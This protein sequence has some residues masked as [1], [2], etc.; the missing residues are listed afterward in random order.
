MRAPRPTRRL[1]NEA[2]AA[3][4]IS[5]ALDRR[6]LQEQAAANSAENIAR[7]SELRERAFRERRKAERAAEAIYQSVRRQL[8]TLPPWDCARVA[9]RLN[10]E[11]RIPGKRGRP[12]SG[13]HGLNWWIA[14]ELP[15]FQ[16]VLQARYPHVWVT[17]DWTIKVVCIAFSPELEE[18]NFRYF[19]RGPYW[20]SHRP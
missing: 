5:I 12:P 7:G 4:V 20:L 2:E 1:I 8:L 11:F 9:A 14:Q 13:R 15:F 18:E 6:Q 16:Q 3:E 10:D 17:K 19:L